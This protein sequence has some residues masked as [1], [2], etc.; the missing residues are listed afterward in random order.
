MRH[1]W[2]SLSHMQIGRYAEQ[3]TAMQFVLLGLDVFAAVI[4]DRGIDFVIRQQDGRYWDVQVKSVRARNYLYMRK[5][6]FVI[7]PNLLLA[8]TLFE[9]GCEPDHYLIPSTRWETPDTVFTDKDYEGLASAPE[10]GLNPSRK[11][12][13]VLEPFRFERAAR[14]V[15]GL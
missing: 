6:V 4:D 1:E 8:L 11:A 7:R 9:D 12:L 2:S 10:Y 15:F 13:P 3:L 14:E 5:E